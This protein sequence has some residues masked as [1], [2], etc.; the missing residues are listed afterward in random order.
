MYPKRD[1]LMVLEKFH[2]IMEEHPM[3]AVG[4]LFVLAASLAFTSF[5]ENNNLTQ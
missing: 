3:M 1:S 5:Q 4:V 2:P